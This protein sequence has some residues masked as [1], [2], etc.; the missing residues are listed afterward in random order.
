M[1]S[2]KY[3]SIIAGSASS[4]M[5]Q[6]YVRLGQALR[7]RTASAYV[8]KC[9]LYLA[10]TSWHQLP[11]HDVDAILAFLEFLTQ[12][13]SR[14]QSLASYVS[15]LKHYFR[16]CDVDTSGLSHRKIQLFI[17]SVSINSVYMPKYK[18]NITISLFLKI[19]QNCDA[20][21]HGQVYKA[22]FL[23][24]Y[25]AFLRLSNRNLLR[26]D[27]IFGPPGAHIIL[28][29]GKAMQAANA[30]QVVQ[31]PS[32]L[33]PVSALKSLLHAVPASS[34]SPLFLLPLPSDLSILTAPMV[35]ATFSKIITSLHLN[36]AHFGFHAF[37]RSAVSWAADH[38][39]PLQNLK[40][41]GGWSSSA[42]NHYFKHTPKASSTVATTFQKILH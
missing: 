15:V 29:W 22:V 14:A 32:P 18:A 27:V 37:R 26:S 42:I 34:S 39:V 4:L 10:F 5:R 9:K 6:A 28:K 33:C 12:N 17:K 31:I 1:V 20:L 13:G 21:T 24:A 16:L 36:P 25:F 11:I 35:S 41:H 23:L 40:A 7:P 30:H 19:V 38:N 3:V 8:T 2:T